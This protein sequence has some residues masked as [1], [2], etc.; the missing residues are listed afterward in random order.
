[1]GLVALAGQH[2]TEAI[3]RACQTAL[4][5]GVFRLQT[6]RQLIKRKEPH[7]QQLSFLE[8]HPIIRSLEEYSAIVERA[9]S[10]EGG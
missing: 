10:Q 2:H 9:I 4:T 3:D 6:I 5:Y 1:M 7:E 8:E